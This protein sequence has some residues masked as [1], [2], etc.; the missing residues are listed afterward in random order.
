MLTLAAAQFDRSLSE[1][2]SRFGVD[3]AR[4][5]AEIRQDISG[6]KVDLIKRSFLF[7][8][9]QVAAV[10]GLLALMLRSS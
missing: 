10:A 8:I 4:Q 7:W 2:I 5:S 1:E 9:G 6:V 3:V